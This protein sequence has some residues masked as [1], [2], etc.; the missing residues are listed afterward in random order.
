MAI[1]AKDDVT[2]GQDAGSRSIAGD[3][4]DLGSALPG[5]APGDAESTMSPGGSDDELRAQ[6]AGEGGGEEGIGGQRRR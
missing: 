3:L 2:R 1:D 6:G 5:C 4:D